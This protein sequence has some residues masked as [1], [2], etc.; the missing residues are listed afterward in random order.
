MRTGW[1]PF[2]VALAA[3]ALLASCGDDEE[4]V[5]E[6]APDGPPPA[7]ETDGAGEDRARVD[8]Q[9]TREGD[10]AEPPEEEPSPG[11]ED[12]SE[13]GTG[14]AGC[15]FS[16]PPGRLAQRD[17]AIELDGVA[18]QEGTA[19]AKAAALGQPAGANLTLSRD[20][21]DCEPST[22]EKGANVTYT[23]TRAGDAVSFDVVWSAG[24]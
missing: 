20:G 2:V 11:D 6:A 17:V 19:L 9:G 21:F 12:A 1:R 10:G 24:P 13:P 3:A 22:R 7:V 15:S 8:D 4:P 14:R 16:A 18:C 5:E 23:C